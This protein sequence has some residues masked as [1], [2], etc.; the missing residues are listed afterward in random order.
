MSIS[1]GLYER[2]IFL[3]FMAKKDVKSILGRLDYQPLFGKGARAPPPAGLS[4]QAD[5]MKAW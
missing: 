2:S 4:R 1:R 3:L 5:L